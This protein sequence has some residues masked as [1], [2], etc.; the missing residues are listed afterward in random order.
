M[1]PFRRHVCRAF[2][3][4]WAASSARPFASR[5]AAASSE[6]MGE[7]A[8]HRSARGDQI[9]LQEKGTEICSRGCRSVVEPLSL[10]YKMMKLARLIRHRGP[11]GG[12]I[13]IIGSK[14]VSPPPPNRSNPP[15][16]FNRWGGAPNHRLPPL[17]PPTPPNLT[18]GSRPTDV[19]TP[20]PTS[21]SPSVLPP[22]FPAPP[23]PAVYSSV[24][25]ER[26]GLQF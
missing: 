25:G 22:S 26:H 16:A 5:V 8:P 20:S 4:P 3:S 11:D 15:R 9:C 18:L 2:Q 14:N 7:R 21:V 6:C 24:G 19:T 23:A 10:R 13:H 17:G 1:H 12:G